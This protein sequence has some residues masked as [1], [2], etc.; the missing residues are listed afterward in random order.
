MVQV[1]GTSHIN[2]SGLSLGGHH[3]PLLHD[4]ST[5]LLEQSQHGF[6]A[7][8][9]LLTFQVNLRADLL[10]HVFEHGHKLVL[11]LDSI[12]VF[13]FNQLGLVAEALLYLLDEVRVLNLPLFFEL[14]YVRSELWNIVS[15][16]LV[17]LLVLFFAFGCLLIDSLLKNG[18][19]VLYEL[20]QG[21]L[22][23]LSLFGFRG[24]EIVDFL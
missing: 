10:H 1:R 17:N 2:E 18:E 23:L 4:L 6:L 5:G 9:P 13:L 12:F 22:H 8:L 14:L 11:L 3:T 16:S 20:N 7:S 19:L 15:E 21:L 24:E